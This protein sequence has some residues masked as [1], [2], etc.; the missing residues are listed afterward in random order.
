MTLSIRSLN[1]TFSS[2]HVPYV[3]G[4]YQYLDCG[5]VF[6]R[7]FSNKRLHQACTTGVG[8][9]DT[10]VT[11]SQLPTNSLDQSC[12]G[13]ENIVFCHLAQWVRYPA[14]RRTPI[15]PTSE[16]VMYHGP[17]WDKT[18][19]FVWVLKDR[20]G[21]SCAIAIFDSTHC[22]PFYSGL[23][24]GRSGSGSGR[25]GDERRDDWGGIVESQDI[26]VE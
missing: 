15:P 19:L 17:G 12:S 20:C 21:L 2:P 13:A 26:T 24:T 16:H 5:A 7:C 10:A 9:V 1:D 4:T 22:V 14:T 8:W 3:A 23:P 25:D 6:L 11:D 18:G